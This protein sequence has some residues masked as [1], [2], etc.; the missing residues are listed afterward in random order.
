M[1]SII[2]ISDMPQTQTSIRQNQLLM[3]YMQMSGD[4]RNAE[5]DAALAVAT[6]KE[7]LLEDSLKGSMLVKT[8]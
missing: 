5:Q 7:S 4:A 2:K 8:G 3:D 1:S 6:T